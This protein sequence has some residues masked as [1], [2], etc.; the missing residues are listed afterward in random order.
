MGGNPVGQFKGAAKAFTLPDL[1]S[2]SALLPAS[3]AGSRIGA[4]LAF[5]SGTEPLSIVIPERFFDVMGRLPTGGKA[6]GMRVRP[7][8]ETGGLPGVR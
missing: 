8:A 1:F 4:S 7:S 2:D 6:A 5:G 3:R